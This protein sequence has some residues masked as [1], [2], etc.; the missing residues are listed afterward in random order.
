MERKVIMMGE[1]CS[2][3]ACD[4]SRNNQKPVISVHLWNFLNQ[5]HLAMRS[6]E[7]KLRQSFS[8]L[9]LGRGF[10]YSQFLSQLHSAKPRWNLRPLWM[11]SINWLLLSFFWKHSELNFSTQM[12]LLPRFIANYIHGC[13]RYWQ[14]SG[15]HC[16]GLLTWLSWTWLLS[17]SGPSP[18]HRLFWRSWPQ[19]WKLSLSLYP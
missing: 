15:F 12:N 19:S 2:K 6:T 3:K 14:W 18:V 11:K 9:I 16:L 17:L 5:A 4:L 1:K 7:S 10:S 13:R 8:A